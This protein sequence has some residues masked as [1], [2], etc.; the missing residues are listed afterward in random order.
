MQYGEGDKRRGKRSDFAWAVGWW[1]ACATGAPMPS[2]CGWDTRQELRRRAVPTSRDPSAR[3]EHKGARE[4]DRCSR[5]CLS[6]RGACLER[7]RSGAVHATTMVSPAQPRTPRARRA[8]AALHPSR[9]PHRRHPHLSH[10][11]DAALEMGFLG[12]TDPSNFSLLPPRERNGPK[13]GA[14]RAR[15]TRA[16]E[17]PRRSRP[18]C[19]ARPSRVRSG[20]AVA[21]EN[22]KDD[23]SVSNVPPTESE[24]SSVVCSEFRR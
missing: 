13:T 8:H 1:G 21:R 7:A 6:V 5:T 20:T 19:R 16:I 18:L 22:L 15:L 12:R 14:P 17:D 24:S 3:G 2:S 9:A 4:G 10:T 23:V 11:V